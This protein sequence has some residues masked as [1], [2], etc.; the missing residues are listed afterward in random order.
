MVEEGKSVKGLD[1]F[2]GNIVG[3]PVVPVIEEGRVVYGLERI[4]VQ[5]IFVKCVRD[6]DEAGFRVSADDF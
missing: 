2:G 1:I 3:L 5:R 4:P 6:V